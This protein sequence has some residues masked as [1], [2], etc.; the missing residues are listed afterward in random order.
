MTSLGMVAWK[1]V[2]ANQIKGHND[3]DRTHSIL[4]VLPKG[5]RGDDDVAVESSCLHVNIFL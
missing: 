5:I 4:I 1:G 2:S 3:R